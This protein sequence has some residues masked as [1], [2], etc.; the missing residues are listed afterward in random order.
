MSD[1]GRQLQALRL[2]K[3]FTIMQ[4][5]AMTGVSAAQISRLERGDRGNPK[6]STIQRLAQALGVDERELISPQ[7]LRKTVKISFPEGGEAPSLDFSASMDPN[8]KINIIELIRYVVR[9]ELSR[10]KRE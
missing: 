7:E 8:I 1:F 4:L 5:S 2:A 6:R 10:Q 9:D 3:G